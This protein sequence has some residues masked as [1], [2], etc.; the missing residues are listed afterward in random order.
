M[1]WTD[2]LNTQLRRLWLAGKSAAEISRELGQ[3][4]SRNAVIGKVSRLGLTGVSRA[5][6]TRSA[7][8]RPQS[9]QG[10]HHRLAGL[11]KIEGAPR[12]R[13]AFAAKFDPLNGAREDFFQEIVVPT[14]R[15]VALAE[16]GEDMCRWP[17]GDP[18]TPDFC[19]CGVATPQ[20]TSYCA[21]HWRMAYQP[22]RDRRRERSRQQRAAIRHADLCG[23]QSSAVITEGDSE[24]PSDSSLDP[25]PSPAAEAG[26]SADADGPLT[27]RHGS[28]ACE[29]I[30]R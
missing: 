22:E 26:P 27:W 28:P 1:T 15:R 14:M 9:A 11:R 10:P 6:P 23:P 8:R 24:N 20:T 16:L 30:G 4:I 7:Q 2:D 21:Y 18:L 25:Q 3:G 13:G 19:Y 12:R 17:L 5:I 29:Q